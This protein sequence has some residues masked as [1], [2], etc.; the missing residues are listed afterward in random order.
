M[1]HGIG[2]KWTQISRSSTMPFV[3]KQCQ[4]NPRND[5]TVDDLL[6]R[7]ICLTDYTN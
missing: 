5:L 7:F 6:K 2:L 1:H 4:I 3:I